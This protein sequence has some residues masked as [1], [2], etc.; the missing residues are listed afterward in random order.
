M[1]QPRT[2]RALKSAWKPEWRIKGGE[3]LLRNHTER[4]LVC[5]S[6]LFRDAQCLLPFCELGIDS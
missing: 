2:A 5:M 3:A 1:S 6:S 4:L